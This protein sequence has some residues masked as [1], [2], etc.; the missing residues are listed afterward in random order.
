MWPIVKLGKET[1]K[2]MITTRLSTFEEEEWN[3]WEKS[4]ERKIHPRSEE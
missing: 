3:D 2:D 4:N 1:L